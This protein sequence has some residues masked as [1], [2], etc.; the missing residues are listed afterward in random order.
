M[1]AC[2]QTL[3][4]AQGIAGMSHMIRRAEQV[5]AVIRWSKTTPASFVTSAAELADL[6]DAVVFEEAPLVAS[7]AH[8]SRVV[9]AV[10]KSPPSEPRPP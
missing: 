3:S 4:R 10:S 8:V 5:I 6:I 7:E 2:F 9:V 1:R